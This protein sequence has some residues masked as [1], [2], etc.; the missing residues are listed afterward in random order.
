ML[1]QGESVCPLCCVSQEESSGFTSLEKTVDM[2]SIVK[3]DLCNTLKELLV[4]Q[5]KEFK[6]WLNSIE[7]N[8]RPN[9]PRGSLEN[10]DEKD[11]VDL[12]IHYYEEDALEV[13]ICVLQKCSRNDLAKKLEE[14]RKK[15][16][17]AIV[18]SRE[19]SRACNAGWT[20]RTKKDS[21]LLIP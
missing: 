7:Y 6:W 3:E 2:N 11:I 16:D 12:L 14:A 19:E 8:G 1:F 18:A 17:D 9:I 5:F 20:Q 13:C 10:T 15:G 4:K 21:I